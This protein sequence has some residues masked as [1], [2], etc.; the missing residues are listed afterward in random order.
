M[1]KRRVISSDSHICEPADLWTS[2]IEKKYVDRCPQLVRREGGQIWVCDNEGGNTPAQGA[3]AG[4][5]F[6]NP[7]AMTFLDE[8]DKVRP[9]GYIP[10][11][12]VK[13]MD[14]DGVDFSIVYP[15]CGLRLFG[16]V[17]DSDLLNAVFGVYNDFAAEFCSASP[18]RLGTIAMVNLDNIGWGIKE[19]ERCKKK[20]AVGAMITV[21]P[22]AGR[23]YNSEEYEPFW[24]A[25][26]DLEMPLGLHAATNRV[27][28]G[29]DFQFEAEMRPAHMANMDYG[30][31]MSLAD[32]IYSGV[33]ER[34]PKLQVGAV[35]HELSW[36]PHLLDRLDFNYTQRA[37]GATGVQF[38]NDMIPSDFYRR[39]VFVGFQE[40]GL[41]IRLRD[42]IGVDNLMWGSDY[43]H[44]EST[45]PRTQEILEEI[46]ADCSDEEKV[47]IVGGNAARIYKV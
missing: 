16:T 34:Y 2:R 1:A 17:R 12:Q 33:F 30:V 38:K 4:K 8:F 19:M 25:A 29:E 36:V 35:E 44:Q 40:D 6:E 22:P 14:L 39:N 21:Y 24:A 15:S 46:L 27:G 23:R 42:I 26:Q 13:D 9:G 20:G 32:M 10:E 41:G 31:K 43:P 3:Q 7:E 28:S 37:A 18:K 45:F 5:R 11:E 47:K